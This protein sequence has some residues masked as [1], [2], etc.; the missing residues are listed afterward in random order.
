M[1]AQGVDIP[2]LVV[3]KAS[4]SADASRWTWLFLVLHGLVADSW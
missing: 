3:N 1:D 4:I 2:K